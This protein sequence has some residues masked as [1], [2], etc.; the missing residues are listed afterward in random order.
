MAT[1]TIKRGLDVPIHGSLASHEVVDRLDVDRVALLPQESWG[2]K[3]RLLIQEGDPVQ[4]GTPLF[5][6]RRDESV[7]YTSPAA[8]KVAAVRRGK[9]RAVLAVVIEAEGF[10]DAVPFAPIDFSR[11]DRASVREALAESGLWP[12]IRRR[13]YDK[14]AQTTDEPRAVVVQAHDS[15]PLAPDLREVVRGR[16]SEV[17]AGLGVLAKLVEG[18]VHLAVAAGTDWSDCRAE[19][20]T[21]T[22]F[23][24]PHPSGTA[25]TSIHHLAPAGARSITWYIGVRDVADIGR[26]FLTGQRPTTRVVA[27]T[28]PEAKAPKLVRTRPGAD[29]QRLLEGEIG[30]RE[31]R[32]VNGSALLGNA[33]NPGS[34]TG[35][36][37]RYATQLTVLEDAVERDF[38][39]WALP[40]SG[41]YTLT[42]AVWDKFFRKRFKFDTDSNG[43]LRA[44][45]PIGV[46][47]KVMPLDVLPTQLIK[48]LASGDLEM[49]EALGVLELAE[50]DLALC[51]YVDPCKVP[52]TEWLRSMLTTIEKEG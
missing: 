39:G 28:G 10:D 7:V 49:A 36:L 37:G 15:N 21:E 18:P 52:I 22:A 30:A 45:V 47:E 35:F 38:L 48:A 19:G 1:I 29:T 25:G 6:D 17:Q 13:P 23:A 33:A 41:R 9:R 44:I 4:V 20:V 2:I 12:T 26:L 40:V 43:S 8:G 14:V 34:E 50:E 5:C 31:A 3:T 11:A 27:I 32:V 24:G 16:E 42:N 51:Q 46:Y